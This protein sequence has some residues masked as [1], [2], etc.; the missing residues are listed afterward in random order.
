MI[1]NPRIPIV[2]LTG[3]L[4]SGKTTVLSW[5]LR[6]DAFARTGVL[7]NE[8]G[9]VAL[10]GDLVV[11]EDEQIIET[12][13]GCLCCTIRGDVQKS[14]MALHEKNCE[15]PERRFD[16]VVVETTGL[17]DPS[18]V[19]STLTTDWR[20]AWEF[21]F[22]GI[23]TTVDV[24]HV[25]DTLDRHEE[26]MKQIVVADAILLTKTDLLAPEEREARIEQLRAHV[27]GLNPDV[28]ILMADAAE[29]A[30]RTTLDRG[31][32]HLREHPERVQEWLNEAAYTAKA[33]D[34]GD[35]GDD[36]HHHH[37]HHHDVNTHGSDIHAFALVLEEPLH[38]FV[39]MMAIE[40]LRAALGTDLLRFKAI[41][42]IADAPDEP[43]VMHAVQ[44]TMHSLQRLPAWPSEDR[45]SRMVFITRGF[46]QAETEDYFT[47]FTEA[48]R[49]AIT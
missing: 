22:A 23:V 5:L 17:A 44:H 41:L 25:L 29:K 33:H 18:P 3:F 1:D 11:H 47:R 45:R 8:F 16:R 40:R 30:F 27:R 15:G 21:V 4:G 9:E 20:L 36:H 43:V 32:Y 7:V 19:I 39:M 10:D 35:G 38:G 31:A 13:S 34:H 48:A 49:T 14:L 46:S 24:L 6:S 2:L 28:T 37:D 12:S 26:S 42:H